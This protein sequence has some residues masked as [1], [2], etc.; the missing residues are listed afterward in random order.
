MTVYIRTNDGV[1]RRFEGLSIDAIMDLCVKL[2]LQGVEI[3]EHEYIATT[4]R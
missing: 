2:G 3:S 4:G 1:A